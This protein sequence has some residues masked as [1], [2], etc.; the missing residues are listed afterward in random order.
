MREMADRGGNVVML[1]PGQY[2]R[3]G[4]DGSHKLCVDTYLIKPYLLGRSKDIVSIFNQMVCGVLI[5]GLLASR[6][7]VSADKIGGHGERGDLLMYLTFHTSHIS[8]N[9]ARP[10]DLLQTGETFYILVPGGA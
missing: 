4:A 8:Q 9:E 5:A 1:L 6:H 3:Q 7:G 2:H 10:Y